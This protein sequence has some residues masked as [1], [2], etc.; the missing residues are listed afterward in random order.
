MARYV[1]MMKRARITE[2]FVSKLSN[3]RVIAWHMGRSTHGNQPPFSI[4]LFKDDFW[5]K[6]GSVAQYELIGY[7]NLI[8]FLVKMHQILNIP[9]DRFF[10]MGSPTYKT[11]MLGPAM[12]EKIGFDS[13]ME[14]MSLNTHEKRSTQ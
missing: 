12:N 10:M 7:E 9:I 2:N 13:A 14:S 5:I 4:G 8:G 11:K 6:K 3:P 1:D